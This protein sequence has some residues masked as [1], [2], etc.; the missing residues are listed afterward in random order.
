MTALECP[1]DLLFKTH[2]LIHLVKFYYRSGQLKKDQ[3]Y[4]FLWNQNRNVYTN[5]E[6]LKP[7]LGGKV[8]CRL[9]FNIIIILLWSQTNPFNNKNVDYKLVSILS[10]EQ[11]L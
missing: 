3:N 11:G 1:G 10:V 5:I 9:Y 2:L 4:E 7:T 8:D 6:Y